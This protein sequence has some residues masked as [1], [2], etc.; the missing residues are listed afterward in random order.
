MS[1]TIFLFLLKYLVHFTLIDTKHFQ[2]H[3]ERKSFNKHPTAD[4]ESQINLT[5]GFH[6]SDSCV[7]LSFGGDTDDYAYLAHK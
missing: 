1:C 3:I 7:R 6:S 5:T 2:A 4:A